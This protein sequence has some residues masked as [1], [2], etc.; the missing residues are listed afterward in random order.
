MVKN[1][2]PYKKEFLGK[3]T[4]TN[5][6]SEMYF[7]TTL[8]QAEKKNDIEPKKAFLIRYATEKMAG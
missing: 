2:G 7:H 6:P 3:L 8:P 1:L 5:N 4:R